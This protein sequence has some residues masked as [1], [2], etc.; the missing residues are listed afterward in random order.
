MKL[1][2]KIL[3]YFWPITISRYQSQFSGA[4]TVDL[5]NGRKSLNTSNA[6]YSFD[7]LHR[8]FQSVLPQYLKIQSETE[9]ILLLGMGAGSVVH[10]IRKE[11]N[12]INP[13]QC[14]EIDPIMIEIAQSE[15]DFNQFKE[16]DVV[17]NDAS[18][19]V[20]N[21]SSTY[22]WII[23]DL[24]IDNII[25]EVFCSESFW[26]SLDKLLTKNGVLITNTITSNENKKDNEM[27]IASILSALG[28]DMQSVTMW[29]VN[30][31]WICK[32]K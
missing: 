13:I 29:N 27:V 18:L 4:L 2:L 26:Y 14:V 17:I 12:I 23:V 15:F 25:P 9:K 7:S 8:V 31:V 21:H 20:N 24:F 32:K 10:I 19:W 30:R 11:M 22:Q 5:I 1:L 16:V 3:S 28:Y 6:N